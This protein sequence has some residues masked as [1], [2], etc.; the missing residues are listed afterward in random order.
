MGLLLFSVPRIHITPR[1][2]WL[3]IEYVTGTW[4][5]ES[6]GIRAELEPWHSY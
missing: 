1:T 4:D 5:W 3:G 2:K 6:E